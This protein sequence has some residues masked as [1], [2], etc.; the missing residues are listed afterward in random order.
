MKVESASTSLKISMGSDISNPMSD[1]ALFNKENKRLYKIIFIFIILDFILNELILINDCDLIS[2]SNKRKD[3]ILFFLF[4]LLSICIFG[5]LLLLL[6]F[7][8][9]LLSKITRFS[10]LIIGI[11][12]YVYQV[13]MKLIFFSEHNFNLIP[14]D[15]IIFIT[16]SLTIIPRIVGFIY[17]KIYERTIIKIDNAKIAEEHENFI[18]KVV[19]KLDNSTTNNTKENE[20]EKQL[21]KSCEEEEIIF[22]MN[23]D[24]VVVDTNNNNQ[25]KNENK[26]IKKNAKGEEIE[27]EVADLS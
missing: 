8:K 6:Y 3:F 2:S 24:K 16:I 12:Y 13:I 18:E 15:V 7:K 1:K 5:L 20:L 14:F 22:K 11:L 17:I 9:E 23:K 4:S 25:K 21:E 19:N 27:E 10:Y 26:K